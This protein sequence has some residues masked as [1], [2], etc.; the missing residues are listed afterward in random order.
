MQAI[1]LEQLFWSAKV[2]GWKTAVREI[3]SGASAGVAV[4]GHRNPTSQ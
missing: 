1:Q 2:G 3:E 4:K